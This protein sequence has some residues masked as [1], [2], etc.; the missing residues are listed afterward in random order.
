ML[1]HSIDE[2]KPQGKDKHSIPFHENSTQKILWKCVISNSCLEIKQWNINH[3]RENWIQL[4]NWWE[5]HLISRGDRFLSSNIT[6]AMTAMAHYAFIEDP[7]KTF[8]RH[9][10]RDKLGRAS[11]GLSPFFDLSV[12]KCCNFA[13]RV[14]AASWPPALYLFPIKDSDHKALL[15][16]PALISAFIPAEMPCLS[17][18]YFLFFILSASSGL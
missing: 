16:P 17:L 7:N 13:H 2:I 5:E 4:S 1:I 9:F 14:C 12:C 11:V 8:L 3:V 10:V 6:S 15:T 18:H